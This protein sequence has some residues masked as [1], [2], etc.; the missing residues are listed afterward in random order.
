MS[1]PRFIA[2]SMAVRTAAHLAHLTTRSYATH[3]A[4]D[5]FYTALVDL[6]DRYAEAHLGEHG[7]VTFP[8]ATPPR[9]DPDE[10]LKDYL[11]VIREELDEESDHKTKETILTEIE[12]LVLS[13]LY[14]L[15]LK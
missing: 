7:A 14:K 1:C 13:T 12:E 3:K 8:T 5:E 15:K 9:G 4:L 2:E 11:E 6:V 10:I